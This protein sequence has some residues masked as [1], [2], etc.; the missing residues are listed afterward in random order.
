MLA[1]TDVLTDDE[2]RNGWDADRARLVEML[3]KRVQVFNKLAAK[4][5]LHYPRYEGGF[6]VSVF[7]DDPEVTAAHMRDAGVFIVPLQGAVRI[8]LCATPADKIERLVEAI[9]AGVAAAKK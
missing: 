2:L 7:S 5:D 6:F 3:D 9:A 8:G 1:V 4:H